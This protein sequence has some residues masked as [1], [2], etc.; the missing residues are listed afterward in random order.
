M[1]G[2]GDRHLENIMIHDLDGECVHVD[3]D[4]LFDKAQGFTVPEQVPFRLTKNV[5]DGLG[6]SG[7]EG[8]FRNSCHVV[9]RVLR[10]NRESV[11]NVLHSFVHDPLIEKKDARP[12]DA[13]ARSLNDVRLRLS[14]HVPV[15]RPDAPTRVMD[16]A[17]IP[18]CV[19]GQTNE[20]IEI[21]TQLSLLAKMYIGWMPFL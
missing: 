17:T 8:V 14:G 6:V 4:C 12:Q 15:H 3:F 20:L 13:A 1:I 5:I 21:A 16:R 9:L 7:V 10:D 19:E 11:I 18:L 2:L